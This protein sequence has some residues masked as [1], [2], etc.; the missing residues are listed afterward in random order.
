M[1]DWIPIHGT[2]PESVSVI[3]D[4]RYRALSEK[5]VLSPLDDASEGEQTSEAST[6]TEI[7]SAVQRRDLKSSYVSRVY[8]VMFIVISIILL[9]FIVQTHL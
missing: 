3:S 5:T 4:V 9:S 2:V 7:A 6:E 1:I 8:I